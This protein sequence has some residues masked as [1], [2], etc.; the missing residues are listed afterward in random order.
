MKTCTITA[1]SDDIQ[2]QC[3]ELIHFEDIIDYQ[4][5]VMII[6]HIVNNIPM[7][8]IGDSLVLLAPTSNI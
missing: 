3:F 2:D 5:H 1:I 4:S 7:N 6:V 8:I